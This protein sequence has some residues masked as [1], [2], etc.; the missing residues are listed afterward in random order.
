M[1]GDGVKDDE[2]QSILNY[3]T[4]MHEVSGR[5]FTRLNRTLQFVINSRTKTFTTSCKC[6]YPSCPSTQRPWYLLSTRSRAS[7]PS[8]SSSLLRVSWSV[9][10]HW[11]CLDSSWAD[12]LISKNRWNIIDF[13]I[14]Q[15][16]NLFQEEIR[17]HEHLQSVHPSLRE[18]TLEWRDSHIADV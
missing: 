11:N 4:T 13:H 12:R 2:L 16:R 6:L 14:I 9:Y 15:C 10:S 18:T 7:A 3:L 17:R 8:S 5:F 1:V